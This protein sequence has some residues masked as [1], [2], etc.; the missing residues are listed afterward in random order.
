LETWFKEYK[1]TSKSVDKAKL[2]IKCGK[3]LTE[4]II[5]NTIDNTQTLLE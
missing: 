1:E 3:F 4:E 2:E 5:E